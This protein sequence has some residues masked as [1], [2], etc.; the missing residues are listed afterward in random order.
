MFFM[1]DDVMTPIHRTPNSAE[2]ENKKKLISPFS[3][4]LSLTVTECYWVLLTVTDYWGRSWLDWGASWGESRGD[5]CNWESV[6]L[7][8]GQV[9]SVRWP[10]GGGSQDSHSQANI[11]NTHRARP[12]PVTLTTLNTLRAAELK[13]IRNKIKWGSQSQPTLQWVQTEV[14][15]L[16]Y[17]SLLVLNHVFN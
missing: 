14:R 2:T 6:W 11:V 9:R 13:S 8:W 10:W 12:G 3:F 1:I 5:L 4:K 7:F 17:C 15:C 16:Y